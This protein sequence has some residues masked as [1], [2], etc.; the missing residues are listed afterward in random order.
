MT[1]NFS[2]V[3]REYIK[4][5]QQ[6]KE[7]PYHNKIKFWIP[8]WGESFNDIFKESVFLNE[9]DSKWDDLLERGFPKIKLSYVGIHDD[10]L[11][12]VILHNGVS[13]ICTKDKIEIVFEGPGIL[14]G[15]KHKWYIQ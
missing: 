5:L 10:I 6:Y 4:F 2:S 8:T 14:K 7:M 9:M 15:N 3:Y 1:N 12:I 13:G 11:Y